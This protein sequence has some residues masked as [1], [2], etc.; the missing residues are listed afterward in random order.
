MVSIIVII[1]VSSLFVFLDIFMEPKYFRK[2]KV[3]LH[4]N[5]PLDLHK[6]TKV[7]ADLQKQV[8]V[9]PLSILLG[10]SPDYFQPNICKRAVRLLLLLHHAL[11]WDS[12]REAVGK[13]SENNFQCLPLRLNLR[14]LFL[15][16]TSA[17]PP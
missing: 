17:T 10:D 4:T 14:S 11:A 3:Q 8:K 13:L 2:Y 6:F 1:T 7:N 12:K 9:V 5:E 15:S 16:F